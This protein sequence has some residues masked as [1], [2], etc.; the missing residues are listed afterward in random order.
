MVNGRNQVIAKLNANKRW[1]ISNYWQA[2]SLHVSEQMLGGRGCCLMARYAD[3]LDGG[4]H[5]LGQKYKRTG[6]RMASDELPK[7]EVDR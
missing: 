2:D 4:I 3:R 1:L 5:R 6:L 7:I